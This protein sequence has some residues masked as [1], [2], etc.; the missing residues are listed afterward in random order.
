MGHSSAEP[1]VILSQ[2]VKW[3]GQR[4]ALGD[5]FRPDSAE[6][7]LRQPFCVPCEAL[8]AR[9]L[10]CQHV[11]FQGYFDFGNLLLP[12][13]P[14]QLYHDNAVLRSHPQSHLRRRHQ[15]QVAQN[16][17]HLPAGLLQLTPVHFRLRTETTQLL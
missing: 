5:A 9:R 14:R 17:L 15:Q 12:L 7:R 10:L 1:D 16:H 8:G 6:Q 3:I 4:G 2:L 11:S 13:A